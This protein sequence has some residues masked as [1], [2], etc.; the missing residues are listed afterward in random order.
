MAKKKLPKQK[1]NTQAVTCKPKRGGIIWDANENFFGG[2]I[3]KLEEHAKA[4]AN[5]RS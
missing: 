1:G 5:F 3:E 2:S 4:H